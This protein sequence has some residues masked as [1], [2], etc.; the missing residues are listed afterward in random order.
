MTYDPQVA[1]WFNKVDTNRTGMLN[2]EELQ[3]ALRNNDLTT[4]D[5]ETVSL[6]IRMFDKDN[7]GTIDVNEFCQLWKYLGDW[8]G[9]FDRFDR[10]GG[11]SIDERELGNALNELGYRLSPQFVMEAMKK[12]D[13]RRER[14]LQF[15]G[16]VHC[17]IL[18]QR[19]TTGFQQFDTQRNGN[20][21]FSYEGFL[22]AVFKH[23]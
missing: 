10:D 3:L 22:T 6:M 2:A 20:A 21:Y 17:L 12:F 4:F 8:R 1:K 19:L 18:L 23:T 16:F 11:G 15:D 13:F 5:I 7:T 9:S 14:R